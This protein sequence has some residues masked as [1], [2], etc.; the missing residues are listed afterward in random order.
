MVKIV[1]ASLFAT[2]F[3]A[4]CS[5]DETATI[6]AMDSNDFGEK[7]N[8]CG[9]KA[10]NLLTLKVDHDKF[11]DCLTSAVGIGNSCSECYADAADYGVAN[12]KVACLTSWC[13][14]KCL[15][16]TAA[17]QADVATCTGFPVGDVKPCDSADVTAGACSAD[18]AATIQGMDANDFGDKTNDCGHKA[19]NFLTLKVD[20][21]K[22]DDCLTSAV[23]VGKTCAE[24]YADTADYGVAN[25]KVACLTS[26]CSQ[27]CLDCTAA[28]QTDLAACTGFPAGDAKPCES[29]DVTAGACSADEAATIQGMDANDFGDKTNDCGHKATN[30]LTLKVD[31]DK[32]DDCLTS[33]VGVG[34]TCAECYADTADYGVANC[35]VACL[36]SWCSQKCL[37]CTSAAQTDLATCTGFPAGD[38]KPCESVEV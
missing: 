32:F 19:T 31:H 20:H 25:C 30:F 3:G 2:A 1:C 11:D 28:A 24:C 23:G 38:A 26:W 36:T 18:E 17:A 21:D 8:T 5:A 14:Q 29:A 15:D 9:H 10:T 27:K 22:F 33:A 4:S 16:C 13:S 6:Q 37:D 7:T 34:K 35:K 12:C